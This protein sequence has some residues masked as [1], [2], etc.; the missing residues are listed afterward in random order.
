MKL[1]RNSGT[2]VDPDNIDMIKTIAMWVAIVVGMII[3]LFFNI[4]W[5]YI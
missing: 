3:F 2:G 1:F 4:L 5:K